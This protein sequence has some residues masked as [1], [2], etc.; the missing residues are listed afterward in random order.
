MTEI[1]IFAL[2]LLAV[3]VLARFARVPSGS[4]K[5]YHMIGLGGLFLILGEAGKLTAQK[6]G[7]VSAVMPAM[8]ILTAL[9]A[10][11]SVVVGTVWVTLHY[12]N[13]FKDA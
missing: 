7:V 12:L 5:I 3:P 13:H 9:L 2:A 11:V 4:R 8:D 10:F 6:I 1:T